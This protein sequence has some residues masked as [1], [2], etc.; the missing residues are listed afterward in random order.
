M[1]EAAST[2]F[3][4]IGAG[5]VGASCAAFLQRE[6]F[7]V[8]L[9]DRDEPGLGC[10]FGNAGNFSVGG[11]AP[12]ALPGLPW[13]VP[14]M[15]ANPLHPLHVDWRHFP[16][17]LPYFWR[18]LNNSR[19]SRV[20]QIVPALHAILSRV[21]ESYEMLLG[22]AKMADLIRRNGKLYTYETAK[23][24]ASDQLKYELQ[25]R[26]GVRREVLDGDAAREMEPALGPSV[27]KAVFWP[28]YGW[29][30]SPHRLTTT[31]VEDFVRRNG[32]L[33]RD[34]VRG[35]EV[36]PN[37]PTRVLTGQ[38]SITV[39]RV[40]IAA[41]IW[42]RELAAE[43]GTKVSM[44]SERGYH[45]SMP[46]P[47][48]KFSRTVMSYDRFI[49]ITPME[50]GLRVSGIG[51]FAGTRAKPRMELTEKVLHHARILVPGINPEGASRWMGERPST[52][53]SLPILGRSPRYPN[54]FFAFG[55]FGLTLGAVCGRLI[56]ELAAGKPTTIDLK[57]YRADRF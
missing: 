6:G 26:Y 44:E 48:V 32:I 9:V 55:H 18:F 39:D 42:S 11:V 14:R 40:V 24:F 17:A 37:G 29:T 35:F 10:S 46:N 50:G 23:A 41:G 16:A 45:L 53:D 15:L 43:L 19:R 52:P 5:I 3:L 2:D 12:N 13:R 31:I 1:A 33:R 34:A 57:P 8:T 54:V 49:T 30:V 51:E 20:E 38:G 36:G 21:F 22:P 25:D 28:D 27:A 7:S 47:G 4:V 56:G